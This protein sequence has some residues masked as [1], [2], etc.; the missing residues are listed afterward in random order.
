MCYCVTG[1]NILSFSLKL[2]CMKT[3][4]T[5]SKLNTYPAVEQDKN[6][7]SS[8]NVCRGCLIHSSWTTNTFGNS[9]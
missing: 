4:K 7:H 1:N 3:G 6:I 2:V 9:L 8:A 5:F